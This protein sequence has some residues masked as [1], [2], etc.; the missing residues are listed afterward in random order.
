MSKYTKNQ[1]QKDLAGISYNMKTTQDEI[2]KLIAEFEENGV[3]EEATAARFNDL[4]DMVLEFE[5]QIK[6]AEFRYDT[7]NWTTANW[8]TYELISSNID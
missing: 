1:Y 5:E 2:A 6:N 4:N 8:N 3:Y 7:R